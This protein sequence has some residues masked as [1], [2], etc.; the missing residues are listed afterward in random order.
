MKEKVLYFWEESGELTLSAKCNPYA[1]LLA[2]GLDRYDFVLTDA[3]YSIT[4]AQLQTYRSTHGILH[5]N[6]PNLF[7]HSSSNAEATRRAA[8][9]A[10]FLTYARS[11][12]Y[13][14]V[15]TVHN[16]YPHERPCPDI[17]RIVQ[18]FLAQVADALIVH[19]QSAAEEVKRHFYPASPVYVIP[20]GNFVDAYPNQISRVAARRRLSLPEE[21]FVYLNFG[22]LRAYK[23]VT[24][25]IDAF[26]EIATSDS[27]LLLMMSGR[28]YR[29]RAAWLRTLAR[30]R[31]GIFGIKQGSASLVEE[32]AATD[33][34][35]RAFGRTFWD[36]SEF[37]YFINAAD[38]VVLPFDVI[39]TSASVIMALSFGKPVIT[40][41]LGCLPELIDDDVGILYDPTV[42]GALRQAMSAIRQR[43]TV[44]MGIAAL[45]RAKA[46]D[47]DTIARDTVDVYRKVL[48]RDM[49]QSCL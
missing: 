28:D 1:P 38:V 35:V 47:W 26:L 25:L 42:Q 32:T 24:A 14:L 44:G 8:E 3:S 5:L 4:K 10:Q 27:H 16:L 19:C 23:G 13:R 6:W 31:R 22:K 33:T 46:L 41:A 49:L 15:W 30:A 43:D 11:L 17:D 7:Y 2:R 40:P 12:G 36:A 20:I 18:T 45:E 9:Y 39:L 37:Q 21:S 48:A 34:R 29:P